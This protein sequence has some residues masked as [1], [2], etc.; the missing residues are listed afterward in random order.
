LS[1]EFGEGFCL[2]RANGA[3]YD[4]EDNLITQCVA[5]EARNLFC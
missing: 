2:D 5:G 1:T 3:C 4:G